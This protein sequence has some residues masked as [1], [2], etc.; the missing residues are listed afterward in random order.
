MAPEKGLPLLLRAI[1]SNEQLAES[2]RLTLVGDGEQRNGLHELVRSLKV[3]KIVD[4]LGPVSY[5]EIP[6]LLGTHDIL[7]LPSLSEGMPRIGLEA[8]ATG[9]P[10][11]CSA[12]PQLVE[13]F[14]S[15]GIYFDPYNADSVAQAI[16]SASSDRDSLLRL[17]R[18]GRKLVE[19]QYSLELAEARIRDLYNRELH[20]GPLHAPN[21][22]DGLSAEAKEESWT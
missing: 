20:G 11:L 14:S 1:A 16:L 19:Q 8:L 22:L 10:V 9:M 17:G 5:A 2:V 4:F 6:G 7:V 21:P 12:L 15:A 13:S 3:S 18:I